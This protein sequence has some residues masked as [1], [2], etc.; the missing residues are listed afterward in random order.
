MKHP[1]VEYVLLNL[2]AL[3]T[4]ERFNDEWRA[5]FE[6]LYHRLSYGAAD[7][8]DAAAVV[9]EWRMR[10]SEFEGDWI[11]DWQD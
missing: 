4:D 6:E 11:G 3:A 2:C 8:A 5:Y 7:L 9:D 1:D 10:G